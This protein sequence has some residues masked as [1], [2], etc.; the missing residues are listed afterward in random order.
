MPRLSSVSGL[1]LGQQDCLSGL[2]LIDLSANR[3]RYVDVYS[4][5]IYWH[6]YGKVM[7]KVMVHD[8]S[9][10]IVCQDKESSIFQ[11]TRSGT[12]KVDDYWYRS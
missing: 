8:F 1:G 5:Y 2:G 4:I 7:T 3:I 12:K 10:K 6:R 9:K 11:Q